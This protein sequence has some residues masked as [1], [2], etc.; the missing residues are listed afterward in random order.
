ME[1][2]TNELSKGVVVY[3]DDGIQAEARSR[4]EALSDKESASLI[5]SIANVTSVRYRWT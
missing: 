2:F 4:V 1:Y 3:S 5:E